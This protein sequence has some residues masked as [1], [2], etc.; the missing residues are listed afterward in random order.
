M[1]GLVEVLSYAGRARSRSYA[2]LGL[3]EVLSY[4][5]PGRGPKQCCRSN[6]FTLH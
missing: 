3:V 2:M 5:G 4:A 1:L 6:L